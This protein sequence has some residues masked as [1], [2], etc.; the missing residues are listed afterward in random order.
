MVQEIKDSLAEKLVKL[1]E[2][3]NSVKTEICEK[4]DTVQVRIE[5]VNSS[6]KGEIKRLEADIRNKLEPIIVTSRKH[7]DA[8]R[9]LEYATTEITQTTRKLMTELNRVSGQLAKITEK[10]RDLEGLSKRQNLR[11]V[12]LKERKEDGKDTRDFSV[13][14]LQRVLNLDEGTKLYRVHRVL[15]VQPGPGAPP[16]QFILKLHHASVLEDIMKKVANKRNLIFEGD[17]IRLF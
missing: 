16:R 12:G 8:I 7:S 9:E 17:G 5:E 2:Q 6:L 13:D 4:I 1:V 11:I 14:L 3:L 15:R 10:C